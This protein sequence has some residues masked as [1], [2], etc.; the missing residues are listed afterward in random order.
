MYL[1]LKNATK[2]TLACCVL[3]KVLRTHSKN[4]YSPSRFADEVEENGNYKTGAME[5][6]K[7]F[8]DATPSCNNIKT[9]KQQC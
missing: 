8:G 1:Q 6:Q 4:S 3:H 9:F 2:I 7:R 5:R